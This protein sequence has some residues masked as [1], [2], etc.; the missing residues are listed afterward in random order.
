M[1]PRSRFFILLVVI[2]LG[3]ALFYYFGADHSTDMV[4]VGTIDANQVIVSSKV[5]GR[6]EKL[7]VTEGTQVKQGDLIAVL[8]S[9]ELEAEKKAA[10][11]TL[12]SLRSKVTGSRAT[13]RVT[14][15][16][17]TGDV[18][19]SEARV[20][21]SRAQLIQAQ[22][23]LE[24]QKLDTDRTVHLAEQGVASQQDRDRAVAALKAQQAGVQA[25]TDMV[26]AAEADLRSARARTHQTTAAVSDVA[27]TQAQMAQTQAQLAEAET[28]LGYTKIYAPVSGTVLVRAAL[29]GEVVNPGTPIVTIVDLNDTWA[30][31]AVPET[32]AP[33]IRLGDK[34][35]V[36]LPDGSL[37]PGEISYKAAEGDFATQ[38][39]VSRRKR[40][41]KTIALK[42]RVANPQLQLVP[43]MTA[44]VLVPKTLLERP[45]IAT[46][47][48][49]NLQ[50]AAR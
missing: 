45:V 31:A 8:D 20:A 7:N 6:I 38:R 14:A 10:E 34:L 24:Q 39:D 12:A 22:A 29:E 5:M 2:F 49:G 41:I 21:N 23:N 26:T 46:E 18:A 16:S 47:A 4:L 32:E 50:G 28:R 30:W 3:A 35:E 15:G 40:D 36:R 13:Y 48:P 19:N 11:A 33:R 27:S 44:D 17:T 25:L 42:V 9:A 37:I 43:G 1:K